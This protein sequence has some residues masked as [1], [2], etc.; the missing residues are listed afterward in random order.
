MAGINRDISSSIRSLMSEFP[1][2]VVLGA[3]QVGK[4]TL[5]HQLFPDI[6]RFDLEKKVILNAFTGM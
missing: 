5:L 1:V 2:V 3:R 6:Q 4:S